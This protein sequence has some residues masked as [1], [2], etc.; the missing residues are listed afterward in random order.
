MKKFSAAGILVAASAAVAMVGFGAP[1][2]GT[3]GHVQQ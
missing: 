2:F 1:A 3:A